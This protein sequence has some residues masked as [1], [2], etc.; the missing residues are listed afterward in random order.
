MKKGDMIF[1]YGTLRSG[2]RA[3]LAK[4]SHQFDVARVGNDVING[5]LYHLGAYPGVM[6]PA[7]PEPVVFDYS[8]PL[9]HGEVFLVL[10]T[11]IMALLDA[12]EGYPT[13]Y[14]RVQVPTARGKTVW[15]YIYNHPVT[16]D[17]LI[18]G[19]DWCRNREMP[20]RRRVI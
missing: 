1:V 13:L 4:S 8:K 9:V 2:E 19:G 10:N 12:Y 20:I 16:S 6:T 5:K 3:D 14:D 11:S 15:V 7:Y 18:E 17:Q